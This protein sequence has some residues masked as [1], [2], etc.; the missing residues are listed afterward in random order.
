MDKLKSRGGKIQRR[1]RQKKED[2]SP[3]YSAIFRKQALRCVLRLVM[4]GLS[5][6][7]VLCSMVQVCHQLSYTN[8]MPVLKSVR[9]R[10]FGSCCPIFIPIQEQLLVL[11]SELE[12][13]M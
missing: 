10:V 9:K 11:L 6:V 1:E 13:T 5:L 2:P 7:R 12:K 3:G 8:G 4:F